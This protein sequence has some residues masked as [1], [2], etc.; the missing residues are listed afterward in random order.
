MNDDH[1]YTVVDLSL[2]EAPIALPLCKKCSDKTM[3][4][5]RDP[6]RARK[7]LHTGRINQLTLALAFGLVFGIGAILGTIVTIL[8]GGH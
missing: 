2:V 5:I 3:E 6:E 8:F 4:L 7:S 1:D